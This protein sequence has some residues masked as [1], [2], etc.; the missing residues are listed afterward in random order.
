MYLID[1]RLVVMHYLI[2]SPHMRS[3]LRSSLM[4]TWAEPEGGDE[5]ISEP[6]LFP[7][8]APDLT[9][10]GGVVTATGGEDLTEPP[11]TKIWSFI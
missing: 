1:P 3:L 4:H 8:S 5:I 2:N 9:L 11:L 10:G 6:S 7:D